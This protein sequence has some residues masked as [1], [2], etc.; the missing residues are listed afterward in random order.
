MKD[1]P[2]IPGPSKAPQGPCIAFHK[3]DGSNLRFEWSKK[4][5]WYKAGIR[6][7]LIDASHP[8]FGCALHAFQ[9]QQAEGI[10]KVLRDNKN[11]IGIQNVVVFCEFLGPSSFA[12]WHDWKEPK[13]LILF[14][15]DIIKKGF[16]LPRDFLK[17]F[18]HLRIA[19]P[20]YEGNFNKEFV[21][22]VKDGHFPVGEGVVAKGVLASKNP[23]HG[24]WR[25]KVK[26]KAWLAELAKRVQENPKFFGKTL[27]DNAIEQEKFK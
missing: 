7:G 12:G 11:Y 19:E 9:E 6:S 4:R 2:E 27:A 26:T 17:D 3:Y 16:V 5:G 1:Y 13:E 18:G 23:V 15:V 21:E 20:V 25:A 10:E 8:D 14:D 22:K 24:L